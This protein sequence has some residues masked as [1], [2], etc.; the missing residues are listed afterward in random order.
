MKLV[1]L[2]VLLVGLVSL[3]G[4]EADLQTQH[5]VIV[6]EEAKVLALNGDARWQSDEL[7]TRHVGQL[8]AMLKEFEAQP[9]NSSAA[10]YQ[11]LGNSMQT[12]LQQL[13]RDC[14]MKGP[15]HEML[16]VYLVPLMDDVK[17]MVGKDEASAEAAL[18]RISAQL[19]RYSTYFE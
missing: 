17:Y 19:N 18:D 16:H 12:E 7:T 8:Q 9:E 3:C 5:T 6:Q 11:D 10:A 13:F 14:T 4:H 1:I 2:S 15:A